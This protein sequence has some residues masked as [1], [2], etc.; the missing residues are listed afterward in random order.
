MAVLPPPADAARVSASKRHSHLSRR[1]Q[2][3]SCTTSPAQVPADDRARTTLREVACPLAEVAW[4]SEP[5]PRSA[6][7]LERLA[8]Y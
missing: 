2:G 7:E 1:G 3:Q 4:A 8:E 6:A 5:L